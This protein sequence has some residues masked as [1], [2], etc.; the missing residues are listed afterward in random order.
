MARGAGAAEGGARVAGTRTRPRG[1][2]GQH[3]R[4]WAS[5]RCLSQL[6]SV[7]LP[8]A[9]SNTECPINTL[10][11][12]VPTPCT[13][14]HTHTHMEEPKSQ[15]LRSNTHTRTHTEEP[16]SQV[17][18]SH[19]HTH[20]R[21]GRQAGEMRGRG[22]NTIRRGEAGVESNHT[23]RGRPLPA[24]NHKEVETRERERERQHACLWASKRCR[25]PLV[26]VLSPASSSNTE[27]PIASI[28]N[29]DHKRT[30]TLT[31]L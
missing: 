22:P 20:R 31:L 10:K 1:S 27:S 26:S 28:P 7:S 25:S 29:Q 11:N 14:T 30:T 9:S 19:T 3:A 13:N 23:S 24:Q 12:G 2:P 15:V 8:A 4:L 6:V 5:K 16:K 17:L 18:R 21:A